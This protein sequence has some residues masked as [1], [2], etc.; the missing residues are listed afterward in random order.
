MAS[1]SAMEAIDACDRKRSG[2]RNPWLA[3]AAL[4]RDP[5]G[6]LTGAA[7]KHGDIVH[8]KIWS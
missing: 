3:Y 1:H 6:Y 7:R 5:L 8:L 4:Y 2:P